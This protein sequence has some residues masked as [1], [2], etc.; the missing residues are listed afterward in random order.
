MVSH[1]TI[2][3]ANRE[4]ERLRLSKGN[5]FFVVPDATPP[6]HFLEFAMLVRDFFSVIFPPDKVKKLKAVR[7][8]QPPTTQPLQSASSNDVGK[9]DEPDASRSEWDTS[10]TSIDNGTP[11]S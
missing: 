1:N 8:S 10:D 2:K 4:A 5:V 3:S 7:S 11:G 6:S 9:S